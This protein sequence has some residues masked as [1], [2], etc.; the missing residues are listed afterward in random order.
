MI[1]SYKEIVYLDPP[2]RT[3]T[4]NTDYAENEVRSNLEK[5]GSAADVS[6]APVEE[7]LEKMKHGER[8]IPFVVLGVVDDRHYIS[9]PDGVDIGPQPPACEVRKEENLSHEVITKLVTTGMYA[10]QQRELKSMARVTNQAAMPWAVLKNFADVYSEIRA[11][12]S[13]VS[14]IVASSPAFASKSGVPSYALELLKEHK[15]T[16][17]KLNQDLEKLGL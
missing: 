14:E 1:Y 2:V 8:L 10:K 12:S 13:I 7:L 17:D 16:S 3:D 6:W 4:F 5:K 9:V 11:L 15:Q